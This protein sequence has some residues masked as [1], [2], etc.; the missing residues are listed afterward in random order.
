MK[1]IAVTEPRIAAVGQNKALSAFACKHHIGCK[2]F[3]RFFV[4]KLNRQRFH[5]G[6]KARRSEARRVY[7]HI[8]RICVNRKVIALGFWQLITAVNSRKA[9]RSHNVPIA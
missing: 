6:V 8:Q 2:L 9:R 3:T 1:L 5:T 7:R 4:D